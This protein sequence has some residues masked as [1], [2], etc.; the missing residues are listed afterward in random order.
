MTET[1]L[2]RTPDQRLRVFVSSTLRE[3]AAER[4]A[5]R[6]AV[7]RLRLVP[8]MFEQGARPHPAR[9]VYRSYLA[10][11]QVF[12][13]IYWQSY[14][15]VA[16]GEQ[17]SGL[18][19]EYLLSAGLPQLIYVK[20]PAPN[21]DVR[22]DRMLAR[23][24]DGG[25]VSYKHFA[26]PSELQ[27]L[28]E[29]DLALLLSERFELS[30]PHPGALA[31][32]SPAAALPAP[33]TPLQGRDPDLAAI[34]SLVLA[35][36]ARL[37][38]LTGPGGVGKSRLAVDVAR[39]LSPHFGDG[40]RFVDL[41]PVK[42]ADLVA[43]AIASALGLITS[44]RKLLG[45]VESYLRPRR[46]LLL[47]DNFEQVAK[48]GPLLTELLSAA[49]GLV[50]LVTTRTVLRLT[51]EHE[52]A[53]QTLPVPLPGVVPEVALRYGSVELFVERAHAKSA[54]FDLTS[55]NVEAVAE[56]CRRLDGLPLAVELAAARVRMLAPAALL[57]RLDNRMGLLTGGPR[58]RP[59]R[60]RTLRA[61]LDWS[62]NLLTVVDQV[63]L[64]RLGVFAGPLDLPAAEAVC[65]TAPDGA[66]VTAES[67]QPVIDT[68][69]SLVD[70]SLVQADD[71]GREPAFRLLETI[72]EYAL[73]HLR[74]SGEWAEAHDRHAAY[75]IALAEPAE[76]EMRGPWQLA[77]LDRLE[78]AHDNL[79]QVLSWLVEMDRIEELLNL[80]W[81]TWRF[82]WL[83][84]HADELRWVGDELLVRSDGM[85]PYDHAR[86]LSAAGFTTIA[87]GDQARAR[88]LFERS[89][90]LA[91]EAGDKLGAALTAAGLGHVLAGQ[92]EE[93]RAREVLADTLT[94]LREIPEGELTSP[95][96]VQ[97]LL[98]L[99]LAANF[100]GQIELDSGDHLRAAELFSRGLSAADGAL[101]Q[102]TMLVSLYDLGACIRARGDLAEA[103]ARL[104]EGLSL[105]AEIAD[106][107]SVAYY[108]EALAAVAS[109]GRPERAVRLL[110]AASALLQAKGSGWL[111]AF[112]PRAPHDAAVL[113]AL[114]SRLGDAVFEQEW[115]WAGSVGGR[116][117][118]AFALDTGDRA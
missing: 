100:L 10:Q 66:G 4:Q 48:A 80:G 45:D 60:Q 55:A 58:D 41:A 118:I 2:I 46:I 72:R 49:P 63:M 117:V 78:A 65:G 50:V 105:A 64:A 76:A 85:A 23:I 82:W 27:R 86:A 29:D 61:T 20:S 73:E 79:R 19:D 35:E 56:I 81:A 40:V 99:A 7:T 83:R 97:H 109:P 75:F 18:E 115:A 108:L 112:V 28:V 51:G 59:E 57:A 91:G 47:L 31:T 95:Q 11:S 38:T 5:V 14:G 34:E 22:L 21:R 30:Q 62:F 24:G 44:G 17:V 94:R 84:G 54:G 104:K 111:H 15:W 26:D 71:S 37:V 102:F 36:R 42:D 13:G 9:Q 90:A 92:H 52:F 93:A 103:E 12:V 101:D 16:P 98:D 3:L 110:A 43:G 70:S 39:R 89:L 33:T 25:G 1:E 8:V 107:P 114:R 32:T 74:D 6:D 116:D 77:W 68:L 88:A 96:R 53:V 113:A 67:A 87:G 69:S 106:E